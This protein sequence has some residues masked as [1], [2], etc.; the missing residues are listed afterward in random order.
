MEQDL[1]VAK[2]IPGKISELREYKSNH[3]KIGEAELKGLQS[4]IVEFGDLSGITYNTATGNLVS[5]HQRVKAMKERFGD[6]AVTQENGEAW[7]ALPDGEKF[8]VRQVQWDEQQEKIANL[9]ANNSG[10]QG[11]YTAEAVELAKEIFVDNKEMYDEL[12]LKSIKAQLEKEGSEHAKTVREAEVDVHDVTIFFSSSDDKLYF[13]DFL[14][15]LKGAYPELTSHGDRI[16]RFLSSVEA[17]TV[18][19]D[20]ETSGEI[21]TV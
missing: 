9:V 5:G 11:H 16:K 2:D 20:T 15:T 4:S 19:V 1:Q 17:K 6:L 21:A 3:R 12:M 10:I 7:I 8:R 18:N 14:N 13:I